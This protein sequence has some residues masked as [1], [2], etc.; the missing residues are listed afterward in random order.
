MRKLRGTVVIAASA[1]LVAAGVLAAA[2][3]AGTNAIAPGNLAFAGVDPSDGMLDIYVAKSDGTAQS[4]ITN[5]TSVH[6]DSSPVW[7][8]EGKRIVFTRQ[9]ANRAGSN[10]MLVNAD[11]SGLV[12]ITSSLAATSASSN[13]DPSWSANG[14]RVVF[15]SNRVGNY[16]LYWLQPGS[17]QVYRLTKTSAPVQNVHPSWSPDGKSIVFSRSGVSASTP[18][19][20]ELFLLKTATGQTGRLTSTTRGLG[21]RGPVFSPTGADIAFYSD[22]KGNNDVYVLHLGAN[23]VEQLTTWASSETEPSYAPDNSALVFVSNHSGATE[24]WEQNLAGLALTST[25]IQITSD[26]Q[27]KSHPSWGRSA[28]TPIPS[29]ATNS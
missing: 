23:R 17:S 7:S 20:A 24:L 19:A 10:I 29:A 5:D 4:N 25:P 12:R 22:R 8:P 11:G 27:F 14:K 26:K 15:A 6:K 16:D 1:A 13:I 2:G 21:D 28:P 9:I 3:S 18:A